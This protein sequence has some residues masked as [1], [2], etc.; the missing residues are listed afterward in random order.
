[1]RTAAGL[2]I[3]CAGC[4]A[5]DTASPTADRIQKLEDEVSA[6]QQ[7]LAAVKAVQGPQGPQGPKGDPGPMGIPGP[8]GETG[9]P[10][11]DG[12]AT[13]VPHLIDNT[14]KDLGIYVGL[15]TSVLVVAQVPLTVRWDDNGSVLYYDGPNCTGKTYWLSGIQTNNGS[16][17]TVTPVGTLFAVPGPAV[18]FNYVSY[19][20]WPNHCVSSG[21]SNM[22]FVASDT[23]VP[24]HLYDQQDLTVELR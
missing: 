19:R 10:G 5:A 14:G 17:G 12:Q 18:H 21:G 4:G 1:M 23:G 20:T 2:L 22:G 16:A 15:N 9:A 8:K 13:K 3:I 11:I 7:Q 24:G 6:L